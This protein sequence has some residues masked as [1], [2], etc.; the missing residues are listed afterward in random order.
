MPTLTLAIPFDL[1]KEMEHM[2]EINWSQIAREAIAKTAAEYKLFKAIV[3]KSKLQQKDAMALGSKVND[4][5]Y[6]EY[7]RR[8]Q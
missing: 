2:P 1:K 7:K 4:A 6:R 3:A 8:L 5:L